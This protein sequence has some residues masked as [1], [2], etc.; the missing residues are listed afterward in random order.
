MKH[1]IFISFLI[2]S[3]TIY[4]LLLLILFVLFQVRALYNFDAQ[5]GSGEI[6]L[7]EGEVLTVTRQDVGDGW[8]EGTNA[9]G[10]SGL[11]PAAYTEVRFDCIFHVFIFCM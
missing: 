9:L 5:P 10:E 8:W 2:V 4:V 1:D 3:F 11:F 6:A 7:K